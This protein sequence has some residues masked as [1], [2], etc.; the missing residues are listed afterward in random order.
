[1]SELVAK[2]PTAG[3]IYWWAGKLGGPVWAWF[4]GWFNLVGLIGVVASVDY[5][6]AGFLNVAL[7]RSTGSTSSGSTSATPSTS[8]RET[9]LLFVLILVAHA[10][11]NIFRTHLL[12]LINNISVW[13]HVIGVA[14][15]IA[16]LVFVPDSTRASSFV[17]SRADQQLRLRRRLDRR[18]LLLVLP[19]AD[20]ASC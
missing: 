20:R 13:W 17:F 10:I 6:C 9:F 2:Y 18:P 16:L 12:A 1:M 11:V 14:V 15:I 4:T 8:S 19:A 3:G 7:R 5:A